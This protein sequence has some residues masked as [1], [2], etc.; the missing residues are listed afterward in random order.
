MS[1]FILYNIYIFMCLDYIIY[2]KL[3]FIP[4]LK[5]KKDIEKRVL[6]NELDFFIKNKMIPYLEITKPYSGEGDRYKTAPQMCNAVK[7]IIHFEELCP[8]D[9]IPF[10]IENYKEIPDNP[11][12]ILSLKINKKI[13]ENSKH[14]IIELIRTRQRKALISAARIPSG[15]DTNILE[16]IYSSLSYQDWLIVDIGEND[17]A[18][19][20]FYMRKVQRLGHKNTAVFSTERPTNISGKQYR[21]ETYDDSFNTSVIRE[22]KEGE[23]PF[24]VFGSYVSLKD[25]RTEGAAATCYGTFLI[26]NLDKN[27]FYSLRTE[28]K[29]H[30]AYIYKKIKLQVI[31]DLEDRNSEIA[32]IITDPLVK[33]YLEETLKKENPRAVDFL[34][35]SVVQY[36]VE[37]AK[38]LSF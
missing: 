11:N 14:E 13:W 21:N 25:N 9:A 18:A 16:E 17:Y 31:S 6:L 2:M 22:I 27:M 29:D 8:K 4:I 32:R 23:Y 30:I 12:I 24:N 5:T 38:L 33:K 7:E 15:L 28:N 19:T 26:Y 3:K 37:I 10:S 35:V 20:S 1:I 34:T 36:L